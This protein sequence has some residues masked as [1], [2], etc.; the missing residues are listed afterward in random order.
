MSAENTIGLPAA[1]R[2]DTLNIGGLVLRCYVLD[3]RR[4]VIDG[5]DLIEFLGAFGDRKIS[6]D[7]TRQLARFLDGSRSGEV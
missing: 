2:T 6:P 5:D 3:D 7:E 1:L 4:R